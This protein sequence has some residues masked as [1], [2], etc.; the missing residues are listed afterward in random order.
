MDTAALPVPVGVETHFAPPASMPSWPSSDGAFAKGA[1]D[2][3]G[4]EVRQVS[5]FAKVWSTSRDGA[6]ATF[7]RPSPIP[8]GFSALGHY[9]QRN[10]RPLFG[11]VLVARD[12]TSHDTAAPI[13]APPRD[14]TLVWSSP[15]GGGCFWLPTAPDGYRPIGV[16]ATATPDKPPLDAVRC[17]RAD[18][19]D[20]CEAEAP[21]VWSSGD[22]V[23]G[24][25]SAATLRPTVRRVDARSV[26]AGTFLARSSATPVDA[27]ALACLKNNGA[28]H[29]SA[30]PDLAQVN[31]VLAAYSPLVYLHPDEPYMPSS[32][33]WFF[34]NGALLHRRQQAPTPVVD[35]GGSNLPQGGDND[36]S[37]WLDLP[38]GGEQRERVKKGDLAGARAYVQVKPMLG[39]TATDL[40]MWFFYPFNGPARARV[41]FATLPL[42]GIGSHVGDWEHLTLR[43]SNFSGELLRVYF[44][45]HSAGVWVDA[46]RLEYVAGG[47]GRRPVAYASLH[48]HA[49]Y[50]RAGLEL[51]GSAVVGIRN[52]SAKGSMFDTGGPG[53]CE[54]VSAEYLGVAEPAW[55]GFMH[56][57]GPTEVYA[58]GRVINGVARFLPRA[59]RD[60]LERLVRKVFVGDGATGPKKHGSW[61]NDERD[62]P[63]E[64]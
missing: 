54:V 31:A 1:I 30:M 4:L 61:V 52:D 41:A 5:T 39:G 19:T 56:P 32:V 18:F 25:F 6:G 44:S 37:F 23:G 51:Q 62:P 12:T 59:M 17:V 33:A 35:A 34:E 46:P 27:S 14:Y 2:L 48:G 22:R 63:T 15:D 7:F 50:P 3:G 60:R 53:R 10:D 9:A 8:A 57:W 16:V 36:G 13:L 49:F 64:G 55:V 20:E 40:T 11:H 29:T 38:A 58:I 45:Q 42:G 28:S 24:G 43:V 47:G 26:H 21:S